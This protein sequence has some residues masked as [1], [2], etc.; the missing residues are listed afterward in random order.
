LKIKRGYLVKLDANDVEV[1]IQA[2]GK[3]TRLLPATENVPKPLVEVAGLPII[4]ILFRQMIGCGLRRFTV[5]TGWLGERI[6]E[7]LR[8]LT[9]IPND[10]QLNF[11]REYAPKGNI[12]SLACL[13]SIQKPVLFSF[14]DLITDLDFAELLCMHRTLGADATLTS[15]YETHQLTLGE[16]LVCNNYVADYQE[17]PTKRFL[18]CSGIAVFEPEVLDLIETSRSF[19]ISDL[20]RAAL[21]RS[22][23]VA[24]WTHGAFW[25]DVNDSQA[26]KRAE[27]EFTRR[28]LRAA[29]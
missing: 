16:L 23:K 22:L 19:G 17:K 29:G 7:H 12:G 28:S 4:E 13:P 26:L 21:A 5:I 11:I 3:G 27:V 18:I 24:H 2:G 9:N 25:I 8:A 10:V 14:G 20:I 15:H 6:E 1:V